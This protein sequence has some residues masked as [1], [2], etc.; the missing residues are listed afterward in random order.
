MHPTCLFP[1]HR[2]HSGNI[3]YFD[4]AA[5]EASPVVH[6][7]HALK[8]EV[9]FGF[10]SDVVPFGQV[11]RFRDSTSKVYQGISCVASIQG[12]ITA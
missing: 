3:A 5:D 2:D 12:L 1:W 6:L 4:G 9:S 7:Q 10:I 11:D 8:E